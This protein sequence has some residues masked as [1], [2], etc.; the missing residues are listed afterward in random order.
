MAPAPID[1]LHQSAS[2]LV[3]NKPAGMATQAPSQFD[4]LERRLRAWLA[5]RQPQHGFVYLGVPHRLDRSVSGAIV[6]AT[7]RRAAF[8]LSRQFER[9]QVKKLYWACVEG[10][11]EPAEGTWTDHLRKVYGHPRAEVVPAEHPDSQPAV[12]HYRTL[13]Q[14]SHGSWLEIELETGRTHQIRVQ[15]SSRGHPVLGDALYGSTVL[16]GEQYA[17]ERLRAI[18]LHARSLSFVDPATNEPVTVEAP[19]PP[20]R[21]GNDCCLLDWGAMVRA[22]DYNDRRR[23]NE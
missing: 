3:I 23:T 13:R 1:I 10:R 5:E 17:D 19:L 12:L 6:F 18:A 20:G 21:N 11:V 2:C 22:L 16:F 8:K 4:S 14:T 7:R 9:R 15:A